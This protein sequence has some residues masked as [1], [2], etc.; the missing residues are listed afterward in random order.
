M[1]MVNVQ[2]QSYS[3]H[4]SDERE[5]LYKTT[6]GLARIQ[7][8]A[9]PMINDEGEEV[10]KEETI[11]SLFSPHGGWLRVVHFN[12]AVPEKEAQ[13]TANKFLDIIYEAQMRR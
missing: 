6:L 10:Q 3:E 8:V 2:E 12:R 11:I 9:Y 13:S 1:Q 4:G 5:I 7:W